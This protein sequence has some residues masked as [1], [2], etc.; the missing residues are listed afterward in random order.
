MVSELV[1]DTVYV[2]VD[3]GEDFVA[4]GVGKVGKGIDAARRVMAVVDNS[5]HLS[6]CRV[7]DVGYVN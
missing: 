4:D 7:V 6:D 5:N 1:D 3:A 2:G